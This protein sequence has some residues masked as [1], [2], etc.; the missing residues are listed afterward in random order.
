MSLWQNSI[1]G[2]PK[3]EDANNAGG[4]KSHEC[5]LILTEGDSARALAVAGLTQVG[6]DNYGVFPLRGKLLNV[7]T[8]SPEKVAKNAEISAI[9][10]IL[11][12]KHG[13]E[14]RT[15]NSLRYGRIMLMTDQDLDGAHIKGLLLNYF[16]TYYP[17]L[18]KIPNFVVQFITPIIRASQGNQKVDFFSLKEYAKWVAQNG[19]RGWKIKYYKVRCYIMSGM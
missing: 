4:P 14:Y 1:I 8:E 12:L 19:N 15:T 5:T 7:R 3:L 16:A 2:I 6:R 13:Q 10:E 9:K 17:S 18:M 11:G